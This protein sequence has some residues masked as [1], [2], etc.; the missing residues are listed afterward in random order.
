MYFIIIL[1]YLELNAHADLGRRKKQ[2]NRLVAKQRRDRE[3]EMHAFKKKKNVGY[4]FE[5]VS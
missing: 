5:E 2:Y 4:L 3:N 1:P